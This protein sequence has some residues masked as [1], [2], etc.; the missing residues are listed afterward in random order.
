MV[1]RAEAP[2]F[3]AGDFDVQVQDGRLMLRAARKT[4]TKKDEGREWSQRECYQSV[5]LPAGIDKDTVEA[6]YHNG[7]L[8]ITLPKTP[9]AKGRRVPVKNA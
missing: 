4:E 8:T 7:V 3:E 1:V 9:G 5:T 6:R 2:G